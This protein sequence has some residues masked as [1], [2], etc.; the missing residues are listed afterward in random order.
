MANGIPSLNPFPQFGGKQSPGITPVQL[1][2][3]QIRF[4]TSR[5][6]PQRRPLEPTRKETF[7]PLA[8]LLMEGIFS[9]L[10]KQ[11]ERLTDEQYLLSIGADPEDPTK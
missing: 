11:P 2:P 10:Q 8:P 6:T 3:A 1:Q 5:F 4:P 7:A 9:A